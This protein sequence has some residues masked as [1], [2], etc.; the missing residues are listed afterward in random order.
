MPCGARASASEQQPFF[1]QWG[2]FGLETRGGFGA[3]YRLMW[4]GAR[5]ARLRWWFGTLLD[6]GSIPTLVNLPNASTLVR[7]R[8]FCACASNFSAGTVR[9]QDLSRGVCRNSAN[10]RIQTILYSENYR[11]VFLIP[12]VATVLICGRG[13]RLG[14]PRDGEL[15][16][17]ARGAIFADSG[18]QRPFHGLCWHGLVILLVF[19]GGRCACRTCLSQETVQTLSP[20]TG[21]SRHIIQTNAEKDR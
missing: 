18:H 1:D 7:S 9:L 6:S 14:E 11:T 10:W 8:C 15:G 17:F 3:G 2:S 21:A 5:T 19:S 16:I 13:S 20:K 12:Q 4:T